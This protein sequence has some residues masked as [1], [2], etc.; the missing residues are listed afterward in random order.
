M[1]RRLILTCLKNEGPFLLEWVAFHLSIGFDHFLIFTNDCD[2]G[3]DAMADALAQRGLATH[4]RNSDFAAKGPQWTAMNS[5]HT[6]KALRE[7]DWAL[8]L[9]VDEFL[10]IKENDGSITA[11]TDLNADAISIPW[12]FFGNA[13]I[14][15]FADTPVTQQ[16]TRCGAYPIMFPRQALMFK[17]LFRPSERLDRAGIHAPRPAKGT[18][19]SDLNWINGDG[20]STSKNFDPKTAVMHGPDFGNGLA[21]INHYALRSMESFLVKSARG[22]PNHGHVPVDLSYWARRNFNDLEDPT[23]S[24]RSWNNPF[25]DDA[26]LMR[27]HADACNWHRRKIAEIIATAEGVEFFSAL[28]VAGDTRI[29]SDGDIRH[30]YGALGA[31]FARKT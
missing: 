14:M 21:Q 28:A 6:R 15:R 19:L 22:L 9:D 27:L 26:E 23:L 2:D 8:H 29:P 31:V 3:S 4:V 1:S 30:L 16:F 7:A 12:R 13:G 20:R 5:K 10:N 24:H 17:T 25:S 11:L 18:A